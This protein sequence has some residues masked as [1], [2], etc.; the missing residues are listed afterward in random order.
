MVGQPTNAQTQVLPIHRSCLIVIES[1]EGEW[2]GN[3]NISEL[4]GEISASRDSYDWTPKEK[5]EFAPGM[6]LKWDMGYYWPAADTGVKKEIPENEVM[7]SLHFGIEAQEGQGDLKSPQRSWLHLYR[8]ADPDG[9]YSISETSLTSIMFW[10]QFGTKKLSTKAVV[11]LDHILSFGT[12]YDKLV[13]SVM[14]APNEYGG[15]TSL[16]KGVLPINAMRGK[17]Q[18]ILK[19]RKL[20]DKKA[21]NYRKE[22]EVPITVTMP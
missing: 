13:W 15:T 10:H 19:L 11:P 3:R 22:C 1:D 17:V 5:I 16:A 12:G 7:V 9:R 8:S 21:Q 6:T 14:S 2:V 18:E 20:L 4:N